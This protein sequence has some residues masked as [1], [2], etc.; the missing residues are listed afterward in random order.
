MTY[1]VQIKLPEG[2]KVSYDTLIEEDGSETSYAQAEGPEG[3]LVELYVGD[4]PDDSDASDQ[5][6]ANYV[7][8]VGFSDD[9]D[10]CPI[11]QWPFD[12]KKAYGFEAL[13]E[14]DQPLRVACVEIKQGVMA[15]ANIIAP[16]DAK[17]ENAY[18]LLAR[19]LRVSR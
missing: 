19:G 3:E 17:L 15:V 6:L 10:E 8:M 1:N 18:M 13:C 14:D 12:K 11:I 5:A 4:S 7:E 16:D 2:W 9:T